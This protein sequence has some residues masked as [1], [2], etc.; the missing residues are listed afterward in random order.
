MSDMSS[1][2]VASR[3]IAGRYLDVMRPRPSR[4]ID[5]ASSNYI[6]YCISPDDIKSQSPVEL[7]LFRF[8]TP[9]QENC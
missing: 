6:V 5:T 8:L 1:P 3:V 2:F 9:C 4:S 7:V